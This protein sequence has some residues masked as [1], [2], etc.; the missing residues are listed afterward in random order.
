MNYKELYFVD[1]TFDVGD[2]LTTLGIKVKI[3]GTQIL[4]AYATGDLGG[5]PASL[6]CTPLSATVRMQKAGLQEIDQWELSY[7]MNE[8]DMTTLDTLKSSGQSSAIDVE[9][10][11]GTKY[12]NN[13]VCVANYPTGVTVG[14]MSEMKAVF[15]LS[16][17]NGWVRGSVTP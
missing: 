1:P 9:F 7:Y 11:D 3:G 17:P 4:W 12:S 5:T 8:D 16:N 6:D 15:N 10:A 13:G 14:K 2:V